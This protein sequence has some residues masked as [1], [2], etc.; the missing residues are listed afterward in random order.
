MP[1]LETWI[2]A[3]SAAVSGPATHAESP[4]GRQPNGVVGVPAV[5]A[6]SSGAA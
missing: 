4:A 1:A 2:D 6:P 5:S 3:A